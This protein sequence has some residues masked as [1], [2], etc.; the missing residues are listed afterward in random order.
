M[1]SSYGRYVD[2][3]GDVTTNQ[4]SAETMLNTIADQDP[5]NRIKFDID[6]PESGDVFTPFLNSEIRINSDG[7]ISSRLYRKPQKRFITLHNDSHHPVDIKINTIRNSYREADFISSTDQ[8]E[9]SRALVDKLYLNNGYTNPRQYIKPQSQSGN[10][11]YKKDKKSRKRPMNTVLCL[12]FVSDTISLNIRRFIKKHKIPISVVNKPGRKL[13]SIFC[14]SRPRDTDQCTRDCCKICTNLIDKTCKAKNVIY[15][16]TCNL[17]QEQYIGE[18]GRTAYDRL[19]EHFN[20]ANNPTAK[21]YKDKTFAKHY[22]TEHKNLKPDF[23]YQ[24][25]DQESNILLRKIKEA[26]YILKNNPKINERTE[27]EHIHKYLAHY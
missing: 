17:C 7:S 15:H 23:T 18:T 19:I 20:Y 5:D 3:L 25:L 9:H 24:I 27:L 10:M 22:T 12:P 1:C 4:S 6:F 11:V 14:R 2:D 8:H 21:S 13:R 26:R 16:I